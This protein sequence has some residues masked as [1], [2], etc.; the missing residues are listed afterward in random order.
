M[1]DFSARPMSA[2]ARRRSAFMAVLRLNEAKRTCL[3]SRLSAGQPPQVFCATRAH[4][5]FLIS[6]N[7]AQE[8]QE[9]PTLG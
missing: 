2:R 7:G 9:F 3:D 6:Q 4:A 5:Y 8:P 1:D